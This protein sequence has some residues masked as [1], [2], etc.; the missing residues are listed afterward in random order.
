MSADLTIL[1]PRSSQFAVRCLAQTTG[2]LGANG[3]RG[4]AGSGAHDNPWQPRARGRVAKD[5][6]DLSVHVPSDPV[7][8]AL[9][10]LS[11]RF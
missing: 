3:V 7:N 2:C 4:P 6:K 1:L 10:F 5:E 11:F 9:L 8:A